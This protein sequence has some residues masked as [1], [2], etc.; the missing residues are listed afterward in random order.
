MYLNKSTFLLF[1]LLLIQWSC[2]NPRKT[3][4][5][6]A[7]TIPVIN[8][9]QR[10]KNSE[11]ISAQN[12]GL[13]YLEENKLD[14][15]ELQFLKLMDLSP[16]DASAFANL[17]IVY[18]RKGEYD[19]AE[20]YLL[21]A[22]ELAPED[23]DI[24]LNLAKVYDYKQDQEASLQELKRNEELAPDHVKTLYS[25]AEKYEKAQDAE[26]L[27]EWENYMER[28]V[29]NSPGNIVARLYLV[30]AL[31]RGGKG[32]KALSNLEVSEQIYPEFP[33]EA[34]DFYQKAKKSLQEGNLKESLTSIL[35]FH[36]FLK[37]TPEY[38]GGI[39][40]LK[41]TQNT[42]IGIPVISSRNNST[43]TISDGESILDVIRFTEAT[44]GAGLNEFNTQARISNFAVGDMDGDGD[45]DIY[46]SG[47]F[48]KD[49]K[50]F[51]HLL[52]CEFGKYT[53]IL[54]N[55]GIRHSGSDLNALFADYDND[56]F[57]D[58]FICNSESDVLYRN[59]SEGVF[60]NTTSETGI[61]KGGFK[62][63]FVDLDHEGD[64][65]LV[66]ASNGKN[67][68]YRNNGDGTFNENSG[69]LELIEDE[70]NSKDLAYGD[71][72]ND[73][74]ID[75]AI[76]NID[77]P[78]QIYSNLRQSKFLNTTDASGINLSKGC[79]VV[80]VADLNNDGKLDIIAACQ[81]SELHIYNNDGTGHFE[82]S[83][84]SDTISNLIFGNIY[85]IGV[86]DF[87]NDGY[88]DILIT[89]DVN[90][91]E[92]S[93]IMLLHNKL[94]HFDDVSF[95][96]PEDLKSAKQ[97]EFADYNQDGDLDIFLT[98]LNGELKLLR[99]DGGN[100]NHQLKVKLVGLRTGSGKNNYFGIGTSV[101]VRSGDLYQL[102][103]ITST[104]TI[105]GLGH[106][107]KADVVRILWTN[108]VP[109]SIFSPG[110]DQDLIEEQELKGSC[111]FLYTWNGEKFVFVKDMMWRS[112]LGMPLGIMGNKTAYA[113]AG[114]SKEYLKIPGELLEEKDGTYTIQFTAEL[115][116]TIY[117]DEIKL[118][119]IDHPDDME[120]YV[121][122][123]FIGPPFPQLKVYQIQDRHLPI[124]AIDQT[125]SNLLKQISKK[126]YFYIANFQRGKYQGIT[127]MKDLI[128]DLGEVENTQNL[129]LFLNGW[130][131]PTDAS[132]NVAI[133][134]S[135]AIKIKQPSLEVINAKGQW[136]EV[137]SN[138][139]FPSGKNKTV[140][141]ELSDKFLSKDRRVR[142]R[143][144]MEIYWDHIFFANNVKADIAMTKMN[145]IAADYHYRGFSSKSRKGGRYGPHWFDY[146]EVTTGRKWRDLT[147]T[148]TRYGDVTE[149]LQEADDKYIIANAG[150]ETTITFNAAMLPE[151]EDGWKRD[152]LIY[153][154]GWVKD[155]DLNTAL[156]QTV[157]PLP[158][159][160]MSHYPYDSSEHYPSDP[161]YQVYRRK[162][163]T[164]KVFTGDFV[165][166]V[167]LK[168]E[169][170]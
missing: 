122:E 98:D 155:G 164:R 142:I 93:G 101:E 82:R 166:P 163:N 143:T 72:D 135:N 99:N 43:I 78:F 80:E 146:Y 113:F 12:L 88:S 50:P 103:S 169:A 30:E 8:E 145:P 91:S 37:L 115:W 118:V 36:N 69:F 119:A 60:E 74:D 77:G 109:Q 47:F 128:L 51:Y 102:K 106:R 44:E 138:I 160:G 21:K 34:S 29:R 14:E 110:S 90:N 25:L 137:M 167:L 130:I 94:S 38:Q 7:D 40:E 131:F 153:S 83:V 1:I 79:T 58:L 107:E 112:A 54:E 5:S 11:I 55:S 84:L 56:G 57:L 121:D 9:E 111:P 24:R 4:E 3:D 147:G 52:K 22:V 136:Q 15:A 117:A 129:L 105:F 127:E 48:E 100:A 124:S 123:K 108:G 53:D 39:S 81:S 165:I 170:R 149:L 157:E 95:L 2:L 28:I 64:L 120:I 46:F 116:E 65:D 62:P 86:F 134:Q 139:G 13:A 96:L 73:G 154:V 152:F 23:P 148:Y 125:G 132:I 85:D 141:V 18:L 32:D 19:K 75:I 45:H 33:D 35:I 133:S 151:L 76:A 31:I 70:Y 156:G 140:I 49:R 161:T 59:V 6:Y 114:A 10:K 159:H 168:P 158:F 41:G 17:G 68:T 42:A 104:E 126:D 97:V 27:S 61:A 16:D 150:D 162:H 67:V 71:F 63:L 87:D 92:N 66:L 144:N 26:S 89:S 20:E